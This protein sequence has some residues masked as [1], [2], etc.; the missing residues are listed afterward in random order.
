MRY[1][2]AIQKLTLVRA[3]F[4]MLALS[5]FTSAQTAATKAP[6]YDAGYYNSIIKKLSD[7]KD[8]DHRGELIKKEL[9]ALKVRVS[10]NGFITK[11]RRDEEVKGINIV[12]EV[13]NP[14]AKMTVMIGAH[15][16]RVSVGKGSLDNA[17]G[18]ATIL[19]LL[20]QFKDNPMENINFQAGFWDKEEVGLVGSRMYVEA[21]KS[22]GLPNVYINFD[23]YGYGD[24]FWLWTRNTDAVFVKNMETAAKNA[25]ASLAVTTNYPASDHRSFAAV[26][27]VDTY[28]FSLLTKAEVDAFAKMFA[29]EKLEPSQSP[30]VM[31][32]IHTDK[33]LEN[34]ID[35]AAVIR[36]LPVIEKAIR[37]FDKK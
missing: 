32:T 5:V 26:P 22:A 37:E 21:R 14:K 23:I 10:T 12:G 16:D 8:N 1:F 4:L 36:S 3:A 19:L 30:K 7:A 20:K 29:G 27:E 11:N 13:S 31:Q 6:S 24:T 28:S 18:V 35:A 2:N 15:L 25:K 33:D 34:V 9:E 17:S